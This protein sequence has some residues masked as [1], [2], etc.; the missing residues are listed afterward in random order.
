MKCNQT[1]FID[2]DLC[3]K[4]E[5]LWQ[6]RRGE[7]QSNQLQPHKLPCYRGEFVTHQTLKKHGIASRADPDLQKLRG[8]ISTVA[9]ILSAPQD[10]RCLDSN[11]VARCRVGKQ[12]A[13][14][15]GRSIAWNMMR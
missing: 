11:L 6:L 10:I 12:V 4:E 14:N 2:A 13:D 3:M 5:T 1:L 15:R 9:T 7:A 8:P